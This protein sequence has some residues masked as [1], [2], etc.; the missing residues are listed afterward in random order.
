MANT[1]P[2]SIKTTGLEN[3][4]VT[5]MQAKKKKRP[6]EKKKLYCHLVVVVS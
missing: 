5:D 6:R 3:K 4:T 1:E 2:R